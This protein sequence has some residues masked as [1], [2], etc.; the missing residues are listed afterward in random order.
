LTNIGSVVLAGTASATYAV[1]SKMCIS[2]D[3]KN[4]YVW[5]PNGILTSYAR[6]ANTG[7]LTVLGTGITVSAS[8][9]YAMGSIVIS[10]DGA[11][12]YAI[13]N[14]QIFGSGATY[15]LALCVFNR[16]TTTGVCTLNAT[17]YTGLAGSMGLC[18]S[19]DGLNV[20]CGHGAT[21]VTTMYSRNGTVR[22]RQYVYNS[23]W[24][25]PVWFNRAYIHT[26][27]CNRS[28]DICEPNDLC[29]GRVMGGN[30]TR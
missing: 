8:G 24:T 27:Y 4:V 5:R 16:N 11:T 1:Y 19:P 10:P 9:T 22:Y 3:G 25:T 17:H 21:A 20:Y 12:I 18:V 15:L 13:V 28:S 29:K 26:G 14:A 6:D 7:L 23:R 2:P 30:I